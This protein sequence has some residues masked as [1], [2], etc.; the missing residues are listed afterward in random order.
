VLEDR[1]GL[2]F[3]NDNNLILWPAYQSVARPQG[4]VMNSKSKVS[5][6]KETKPDG[7][8]GRNKT[9]EDEQTHVHPPFRATI[10]TQCH[11]HACRIKKNSFSVPVQCRGDRVWNTNGICDWLAFFCPHTN[12]ERGGRSTQQHPNQEVDPT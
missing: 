10:R 1:V 4:I 7:K 3:K 8:G 6:Q 2:C 11:P 5:K 12:R 9:K